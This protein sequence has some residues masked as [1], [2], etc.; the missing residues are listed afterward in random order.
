MVCGIQPKSEKSARCESDAQFRA[1]NVRYTL[2]TSLNVFLMHSRFSS[3]SLWFWTPACSLHF[4]ADQVPDCRVVCCVQFSM[5]GRYVATGCNR[6]AQIFD[7]QTG[8]KVWYAS[9]LYSPNASPSPF[10]FIYSLIHKC[11]ADAEILQSSV[12]EDETA[13]KAGDLYI[14]SVRFSPDGKLLAT[15]AEDRK[16]R[17][18]RILNQV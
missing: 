18:S 12:V 15:G 2:E 16:I 14:R 8:Q 10:P 3:L 13:P 7:V 1:C 6:T 5:D 17:V 11:I 4:T 9:S